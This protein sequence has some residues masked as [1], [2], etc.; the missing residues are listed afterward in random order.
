MPL[1]TEVFVMCIFI[2]G[3][4]FFY[5]I[6]RDSGLKGRIFFMLAYFFLTLSNIF[7]VIEEFWLNFLFNLFEHLFITLGSIMMLVAI[8]KLT[9]KNN[10][11]Y[12]AGT[13]DDIRD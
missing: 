2:A 4:P 6:L 5:F 9:G 10:S 8:T 13:S 12:V 11:G 1:S 3:G 7:T